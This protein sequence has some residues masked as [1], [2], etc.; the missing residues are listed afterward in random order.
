MTAARRPAISSAAHVSRPVVII[1]ALL[2]PRRGGLADHTF[3]LAENLGRLGPVTVLS[4]RDVSTTAPFE[5]RPVMEDWHD[6][7]RLQAE[8]GKCAPDA[9]LLW[10]YVPHMYGRGGANRRL[11]GLLARLR[12]EGRRQ[13]L[14]AH[15]IAADLNWR[16]HWLWYALHH[17]W[18]WRKLLPI[19]DAI[20]VSCQKWIEDWSKWRP[21]VASKFCLLPSPTSIEPVSVA[22]D[23]R[24]EWRRS[25]GLSPDTRVLTYFGTVNVSKQLGWIASA[26]KR[27]Q[28]VCGPVAFAVVGD[29][30]PLDVPPELQPLF[31][32][33]GYLSAADASR[34]LHASDLLA[35]PFFDGV[36]E[37]RTTLMAGLVHGLAVAT[38]WGHNTGTSLRSANFLSLSPPH[39]ERSFVDSVVSTLRDDT[40][41]QR[42]ARAGRDTYV[43]D[44]SWDVVT[45]RLDGILQASRA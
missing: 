28:A 18:Q 3:R 31:K 12:G 19:P 45:K 7:D 24:I 30:P 14:I 8:I 39:D 43:R 17:R 34:A 1:S 13:V 26:W 42:L 10:Q 2:P 35:L 5:V 44:Y 36:S 22:P 15:E 11:P 21:D 27:A 4:S 33:L 41:R 38:T 40:G 32:P 9:V 20:P 6:V 25:L 23:H 29:K 37:R 16:P